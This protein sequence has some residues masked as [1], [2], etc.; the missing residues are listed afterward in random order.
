VKAIIN[1]HGGF[2]R[3][4]DKLPHGTVMVVTL[5]YVRPGDHRG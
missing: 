5:P 4:E 3:V 2:V 1:D